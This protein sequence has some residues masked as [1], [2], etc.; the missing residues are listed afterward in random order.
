MQI[1]KFYAECPFEIGDKIR[2]IETNEI[3]EI[4]DIAC[5][6]YIKSKKIKFVYQLNN[7]KK[8]IDMKMKKE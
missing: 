3:K 7:E 4:T 1:E 2:E 8:Y 5:I 6:H